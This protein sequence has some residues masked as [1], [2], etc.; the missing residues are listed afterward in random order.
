MCIAESL[1]SHVAESNGPLATAVH[2]LVAM[3]R[4]KDRRCD[5]FCQLLHVGGLYVDNI[6]EEEGGVKGS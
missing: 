4:V 5:N 1:L 6:L 2:K 3:D